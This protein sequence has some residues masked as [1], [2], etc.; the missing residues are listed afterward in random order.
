MW[1]NVLKAVGFALAMAAAAYA[2][3]VCTKQVV[4]TTDTIRKDLKANSNK[5]ET[6]A[7]TEEV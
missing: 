4:T 2:Q 3:Q 1:K 6:V 7:T 5:T